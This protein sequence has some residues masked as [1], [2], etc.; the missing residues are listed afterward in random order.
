VA[1]PAVPGAWREQA[2]QV[3]ARHPGTLYETKENGFAIHYRQAPQAKEAV[4]Q[5]LQAII[6]GATEQFAVMGAHMAWEVV[7]RGADK[8][9]AVDRL[10]A[11]PPFAGRVPVYIGDDVTDE[12]AIRAAQLLGGVGL[13]VQDAFGTPADV[14]AWLATLVQ[15]GAA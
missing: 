1:L 10:M 3:A 8:G 2:R 5:A 7:P 14:R 4:Q 13:R 15:K 9:Q 6:A 11:R 12:D